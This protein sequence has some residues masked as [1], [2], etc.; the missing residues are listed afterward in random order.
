MSRSYKKNPIYTD[1]RTPTPKKS[2]KYANKKVK[3]TSNLPNGKAYKKVY[4]SYDIHDYVSRWTWE[5]AK[6]WYLR[7]SQI[8]E[9]T[10]YLK[11]QYPTLKLF[12]RYWKKTFK[13]K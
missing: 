1:G 3:H 5:E 4:E 12:Y 13:S 7:K 8:E 11:K 6:E 9:W 10:H 2:K